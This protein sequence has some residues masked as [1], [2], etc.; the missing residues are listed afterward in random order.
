M[1]KKVLIK[2]LE[3]EKWY[4]VGRTTMDEVRTAE[5]LNKILDRII[6]KVKQA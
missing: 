5:L 2:L 1:D 3:D 4:P 6:E